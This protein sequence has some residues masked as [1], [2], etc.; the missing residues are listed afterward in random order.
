MR[1]FALVAIVAFVWVA[2]CS[3][4]GDKERTRGTRAGAASKSSPAT[5]GVPRIWVLAVGVS[6]Y[7]DAS[8]ALEFADRDATAVDGFFASEVGGKV[9]EDRHMLLVNEQATR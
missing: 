8:L 7:K 6:N 5:K 2:G 4:G 3:G 1:A 9:P